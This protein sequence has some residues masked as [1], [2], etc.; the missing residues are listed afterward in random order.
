PSKTDETLVA[1]TPFVVGVG[2]RYGGTMWVTLQDGMDTALAP[3]KVH[4]ADITD[5]PSGSA[6]WVEVARHVAS[7]PDDWPTFTGV[8]AA[9]GWRIRW[10]FAGPGNAGTGSATS[11]ILL[12]FDGDTTSGR[13]LWT[14]GAASGDAR[15][16]ILVGKVAQGGGG[17]G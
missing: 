7:G 15:S 8:P 16:S 4:A 5:L 12:N 10:L 3:M 17:M 2:D 11:D 14:S 9:F 6:E 1:G 13:Y